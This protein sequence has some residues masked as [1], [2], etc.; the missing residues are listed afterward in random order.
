MTN[1]I[2][3]TSSYGRGNKRSKYTGLLEVIHYVSSDDESGGYGINSDGGAF[4]PSGY[5]EMN[6]LRWDSKSE[7]V[8][9]LPRK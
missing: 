7:L 6:S 2:T 4:Y 5:S 8:F 1:P 9:V 3:A